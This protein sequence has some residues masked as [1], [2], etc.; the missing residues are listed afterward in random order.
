MWHVSLLPPWQGSRHTVLSVGS[1]LPA[2]GQWYNHRPEREPTSMQTSQMGSSTKTKT[3]IS[4]SEKI[5]QAGTQYVM[6]RNFNIKMSYWIVFDKTHGNITNVAVAW[7]TCFTNVYSVY[8]SMYTQTKLPISLWCIISI[9]FYQLLI[10]K[11][12]TTPY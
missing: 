3:N 9:T 2:S 12:S 7:Y 6:C 8:I 5:V 4:L 11:I 1:V 10:L